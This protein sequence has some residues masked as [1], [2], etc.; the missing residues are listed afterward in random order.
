VKPTDSVQNGQRARFF[1]RDFLS[2]CQKNLP[3]CRGNHFSG[4]AKEKIG[5]AEDFFGLFFLPPCLGND[6]SGKEKDSP[7]KGKERDSHDAGAPM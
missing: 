4:K 2:P 5:R 1:A 6:F 3:P 7:G